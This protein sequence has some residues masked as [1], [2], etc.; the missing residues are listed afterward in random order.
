MIPAL[1]VTFLS[2]CSAVIF[3]ELL[4]KVDPGCGNVVTFCAF[5]FISA[6]G[7]VTTMKLG[8]KTPQVPLT[9]WLKLVL[10]FFIV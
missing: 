1:F 2:C 3:L 6:E 10:F 7:F 9:E 8:Q 5:L 4:I